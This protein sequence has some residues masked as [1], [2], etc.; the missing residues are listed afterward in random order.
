MH[1][2][3]PSSVKKFIEREEGGGTIFTKLVYE[4]IYHGCMD[5]GQNLGACPWFQ[6]SAGVLEGS[7]NG[8]HYCFS[9]SFTIIPSEC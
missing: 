8:V 1:T 4:L 7:M 6:V 5:L 3:M 9:L 2:T